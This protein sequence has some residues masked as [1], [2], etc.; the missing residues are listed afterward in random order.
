MLG[1]AKEMTSGRSENVRWLITIS[2]GRPLLGLGEAG[3]KNL[4]KQFALVLGS[5]L[6]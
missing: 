5:K 1:V 6:L 4:E 3:G 2:P